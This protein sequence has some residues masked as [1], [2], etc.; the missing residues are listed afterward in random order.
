V[1]ETRYTDTALKQLAR[2]PRNWRE[3]IIEKI[4]AV[5]ADPHGSIPNAKAMKGRP[6]Y[7]LRVGDWRVLYELDDGVRVVT[8]VKVAARSGV[9]DG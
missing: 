6:L 9:Y 5:A 1:Y 2:L 8:V 3:R 7:R 4:R